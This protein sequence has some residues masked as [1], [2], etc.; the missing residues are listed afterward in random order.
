LKIKT[1][2]G[3]MMGVINSKSFRNALLMSGIVALVVIFNLMLAGCSSNKEK[4]EQTPEEQGT[5]PADIGGQSLL[6]TTTTP[7]PAPPAQ[8]EEI[9]Q[10]PAP[11]P[12][13]KPKPKVTETPKPAEPK[14]V[15]TLLLAENTGLEISLLTSLS[16]GVNT[17][18][19]KF[20]ALVKGPA[21]E[22]QTV[23]L[24]DG[25]ILEGKIAELNDG[26]A[27]D[28]KASIKLEFTSLL[29]PG[30]Q[31]IAIQGSV[32]TKDGSG[33][34]RPGDQGTSI[35]RDAAVGAAAGGILGAVTGGKAKDA[36]KGAVVGAAAG[37]ILGA[38]LHKDQVTIKEGQTM[39]INIATPVYQ[40]K[41]SKE[42]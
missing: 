41:I 31:P 37:G 4:T 26:K 9:A 24:P 22:G 33:V 39:K 16:T 3:K 40:E 35:A 10:K 32:I 21:A 42:L 17:V 30:E 11:K 5:L 19:E 13:P 14:I 6:D 36:A 38:V 1:Q 18:G 2:G 27:K 29:L 23:D 15:K 25:T 12:E 7:P 34:L 28:E 20:R 8:K